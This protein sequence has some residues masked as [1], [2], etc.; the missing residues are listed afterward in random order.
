[1]TFWM[2]ISRRSPSRIS[3]GVRLRRVSSFWNSSSEMFFFASPYAVS[4][5]AG[6]T[7]S[8]NPVALARRMSWRMSSLS[9]FNFAVSVSSS[10]KL[11]DGSDV[12][13]NAFSTSSRVIVRPSTTA[14]VSAETV[15]GAWVAG[16][17][18]HAPMRTRLATPAMSS[19]GADRLKN[20]C[21]EAVI[22][23]NTA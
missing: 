21:I 15:C 16:A 1:M 18:R 3:S 2:S 19:D 22:V 6:V 17:D 9:R 14:Q 12:R 10:D 11:C 5:S 7:S 8:F 13:R 20:T 23:V 4:I